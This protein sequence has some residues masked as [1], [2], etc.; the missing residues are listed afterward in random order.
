MKVLSAAAEIYPLVKTGG[1][2]DVVGALPAA[3]AG[4]GVAMRCIVPGYRPVMSALGG[5]TVLHRYA[6]LFGGP[7]SLVAGKAGV[8]ISS[9]STHR[10]SMTGRAIPISGRTA[11]MAGQCTAFRGAV[12]GAAKWRAASFPAISPTFSICMTGRQR[13]LRSM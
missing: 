11:R 13:S 7:A 10:I 3:L 6:D 2:A 5:I 8:S 4:Q 1:L 12:P 9:P